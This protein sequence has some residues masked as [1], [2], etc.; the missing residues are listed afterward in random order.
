LTSHDCLFYPRAQ[1]S[2]V[3][4]FERKTARKNSAAPLT[5]TVNGPFSANNSEALRDAALDDLGIALLPDFSAQSGVQ[6]RKLVVVLPEWRPVGAFAEQVYVV[7][8]QTAHVPRAVRLFIAYLRETFA[9]GFP[10]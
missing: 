7:R 10:L 6:S 5:L 9:G 4:S 1:G 8:P 2:G 3:W